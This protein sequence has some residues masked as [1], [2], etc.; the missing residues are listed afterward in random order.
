[1]CLIVFSWKAHPYYPLILAGN[2]DEFYK[3]PAKSV[4]RWKDK[5]GIVAG[6][7]LKAGG[8]WLGISPNGRFAAVT[9]VR[10]MDLRSPKEN[11]PSRGELI[12][13]YLTTQL[14]PRQ[15]LE[16]LKS[17]ASEYNGF[18]LLCGTSNQMFHLSNKE[19]EIHQIEPGIHAVSNATLD[20]PWPKT[21]KARQLFTAAM[22]NK[23]PNKEALFDILT[24]T[25]RFPADQ[26]PDT[27]LPAD[28][29]QAVS[30]IF[31]QTANYGTRCSS[32]L[33]ADSKSL[34][35]SERTWKE[36]KPEAKQTV[37]EQV[38]IKD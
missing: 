24:D 19:N 23:T 17:V 22:E 12:P 37:R 34:T 4:H 21:E 16:D 29:E 27:G 15:F 5:P 33:F 35:L 20:T 8:T 28:M 2:R 25:E 26:L 36:G 38:Q 6:R 1:M 9:N 31:I 10:D 7:D 13:D 32:L 14:S 3:R 30:S 11:P 18:N